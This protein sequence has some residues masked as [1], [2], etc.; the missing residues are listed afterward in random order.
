MCLTPAAEAAPRAARPAFE[1]PIFI[2]TPIGGGG[3]PTS[4]RKPVRWRARSSRLRQAGTTSTKRNS[5]ALSS[6]SCEAR[7]IAFS[8]IAFS[9][10]RVTGMAAASRLPMSCSS[11]SRARS[12][13]ISENITTMAREPEL[14]SV[15][16]P[17]HDEEDTATAFHARVAAALEGVDFELV[18]AD[19][20]SRDGTGAVLARSP[21]RTTASRSSRSRATSGTRRRSPPRSST[22]AATWW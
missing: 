7:S 15:A 22:P 8:S 20:G 9:G 19:D 10:L 17:M 21:H 18:I 5:A 3:V 12:S 14:V 4:P 16:A 13:T 2:A 6:A 1:P 11:C